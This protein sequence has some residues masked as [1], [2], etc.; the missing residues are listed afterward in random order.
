MIC[1]GQTQFFFGQFIFSIYNLWI[2]ARIFV[3]FYNKFL[4]KFGS[5]ALVRH[6]KLKSVNSMNEPRGIELR[7]YFVLAALTIC[8]KTII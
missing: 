7:L 1:D 2:F 6:C 4:D 8:S 5:S 3:L